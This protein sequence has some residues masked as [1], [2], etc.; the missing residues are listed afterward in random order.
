MSNDPTL[1]RGPDFLKPL[2]VHPTAGAL[3]ALDRASP[4]S[5]K[6]SFHME[7]QKQSNWCWA[8]V[9]MSVSRL[10]DQKSVWQQC[11]VADRALSRSDCCDAA[12]NDPCNIPWHLDRALNV[13]GNFV[14]MTDNSET[15]QTASGEIDNGRPL[16]CRIGWRL[17]S[18]HFVAIYGWLLGTSGTE[19]FFVSDPIYGLTRIVR[20]SFAS[21][22]QGGGT[23][24]HSYFVGP[25]SGGGAIAFSTAPDPATIGA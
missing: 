7:R 17:G 3:T 19:Y 12:A 6:L 18:A 10:F 9:S 21:K 13:T 4:T 2:A 11:S 25:N 22:Y 24:T 14:R 20:S 1:K 8:A 5:K 15:F 16:C 23:W